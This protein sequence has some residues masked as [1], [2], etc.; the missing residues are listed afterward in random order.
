MQNIF[1]N[2]I[3]LLA[4]SG[5]W[6]CTE[7]IEI[8]V[9]SSY[10][11]LVVEGNISTDT[12]QHAVRLSK[13]SDYFY[14]KPALSVSGAMVSISDGDSTVLL[15]ES[16]KY[17]GTYMTD[18]G[19]YGVP[20]KTYTLT[21]SHVDV[22]ENGVFEEY[23]ASSELK[24]IISIDSIQLEQ[25]A[26]NNY[27]FYEILLFAWDPPVKN[28]YAFKVLKNGV[29]IKDSLN[30]IIVQDDV[31]FN[32]NYTYGI[33]TQFLDQNKEDEIIMPGD[34]ITFEINGITEEYY[35][36]VIEAQSEIFYQT[37]LF[38]GPPANISSNISNDAIGFFTA[39]SVGRCSVVY[40]GK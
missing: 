12:M 22:D 19:F 2:I 6:Q 34:T 21:I 40:R 4:I 33:P 39:Y 26:G 36:F 30:E 35:K 32:G 23:N 1:R 16:Q 31:F 9:D 28:F 38:S 18:P 29:L 13:S 10:T 27:N 8:E 14:N 37:P 7:R 17:P 15:D 25:L 11:R 3:Y 20:G 24:P 5:L